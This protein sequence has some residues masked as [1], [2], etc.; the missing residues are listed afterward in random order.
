M[1]GTRKTQDEN[2]TV[3]FLNSAQEDIHYCNVIFKD[4]FRQ[5]ISLLKKYI[6]IGTKILS[7]AKLY[8]YAFLLF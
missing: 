1:N 5:S 4:V 7:L 8:I 2:G 3:L 6:T